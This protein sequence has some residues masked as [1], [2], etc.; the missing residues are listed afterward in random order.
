MKKETIVREVIL[1]TKGGMPLAVRYTLKRSKRRTLSIVITKEGTLEMHAPW[2]STIA[3]IERFLVL[4]QAWILAKL[5]EKQQR[6]E[7]LQRR[8]ASDPLSPEQHEYLKKLYRGKAAEYIPQRCA[9]YAGILGV[10]YGRISIREQKTRWGSCSAKKNLN[11]NWKLM[12]APPDVLDYV[13]VHE[14]C[15]LIHLDH[16]PA[17]WAL[18]GSVLPDYRARRRWLKEHGDELML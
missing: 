16:S 14:L 6:L 11:F 17:F 2:F 12:L 5:A 4:K 9:Y 13:V 3:E 10:S 1:H 15:H 18:V 7:E 8:R